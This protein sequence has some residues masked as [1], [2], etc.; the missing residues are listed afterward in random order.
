ML[1]LSFETFVL[2]HTVISIIGIVTGL[3]ALV[4]MLRGDESGRARPQIK[5][6]SCGGVGSRRNSCDVHRL[7]DQQRGSGQVGPRFVHGTLGYLL[8][9]LMAASTSCLHEL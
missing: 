4:G 8:Q 1:G 5:R 2:L 6:G 7:Y 3:I 9:F